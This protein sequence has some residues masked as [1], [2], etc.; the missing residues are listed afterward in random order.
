[1]LFSL[2]SV[3]FRDLP[4]SGT[5]SRDLSFLRVLRPIVYRHRT[6]GGGTNFRHRR[7]G[8]RGKL[9]ED[10]WVCSSLFWQGFWAGV[11]GPTPSTEIL[12]TTSRQSNIKSLRNNFGRV[13]PDS[14]V[15]TQVSQSKVRVFSLRS[16]SKDCQV[17]LSK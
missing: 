8:P 5:S 1:M 15:E 7:R 11:L 14:V 10:K 13:F 9:L 16:H 12:P 3:V 17:F 6:R 2:L 4:C